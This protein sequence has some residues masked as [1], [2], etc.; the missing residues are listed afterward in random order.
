M[1]GPALQRNSFLS[2]SI[3]FTGQMIQEALKYPEAGWV[4]LL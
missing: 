2:C 1:M 3:A 4:Y